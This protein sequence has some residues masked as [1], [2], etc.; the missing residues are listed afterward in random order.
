[1]LHNTL[2][3]VAIPPIVLVDQLPMVSLPNLAQSIPDP[4]LKT[5]ADKTN[6]LASQMGELRVYQMDTA[7][8]KGP[9]MKDRANVWCTNCKRQGHTKLG[10]P[11]PLVVITQM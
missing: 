1:M 4:N 2:A 8:N 3:K 9:S 11:S 7:D 10:C 6:E 5:V